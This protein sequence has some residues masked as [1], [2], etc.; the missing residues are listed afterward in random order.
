MNF[1]LNFLYCKLVTEDEISYLDEDATE[2]G[3]RTTLR[4][5]ADKSKRSKHFQE[6]KSLRYSGC[7]LDIYFLFSQIRL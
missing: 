6:R 7:N 5:K 3:L 1:S 4:A 2:S